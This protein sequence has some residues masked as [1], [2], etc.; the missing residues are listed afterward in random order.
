MGGM[1]SPAMTYQHVLV[2]V[3]VA[4]IS[5]DVTGPSPGSLSRA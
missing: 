3:G 5:G 2:T 4:K 1:G